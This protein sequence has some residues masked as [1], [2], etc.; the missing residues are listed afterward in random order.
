MIVI[1]SSVNRI[2]NPINLYI[3]EVILVDHYL[4]FWHVSNEHG[5]RQMEATL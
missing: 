1:T 3:N 2:F 4:S 5:E